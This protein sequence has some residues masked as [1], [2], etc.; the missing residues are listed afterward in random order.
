MAETLVCQPHYQLLVLTSQR[1]RGEERQQEAVAAPPLPL[2]TNAHSDYVPRVPPV[3]PTVSVRPVVQVSREAYLGLLLFAHAKRFN[4]LKRFP[5]IS[6]YLS[7]KCFAKKTNNLGTRIR[8]EMMGL[9][10]IIFFVV[11]F[12]NVKISTSVKIKRAYS[13]K[14]AGEEGGRFMEPTHG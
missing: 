5:F 7:R 12:F 9:W 14:E 10:L 6:S 1:H 13:V 11:F 3:F 8:Y 2:G 4:R